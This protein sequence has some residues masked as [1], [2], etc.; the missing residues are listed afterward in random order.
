MYLGKDAL[1]SKETFRIASGVFLS[2]SVM[3]GPEGNDTSAMMQQADLS[4]VK[5]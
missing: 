5:S 1:N 3:T 4:S 2:S